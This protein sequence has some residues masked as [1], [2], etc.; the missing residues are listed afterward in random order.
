MLSISIPQGYG[1]NP[2]DQIFEDVLTHL[3][4]IYLHNNDIAYELELDLAQKMFGRIFAATTRDLKDAAIID[5]CTYLSMTLMNKTSVGFNGLVDAH[6]KVANKPQ[7]KV[8]LPKQSQAQAAAAQ[9]KHELSIEVDNIKQ[10]IEEKNFPVLIDISFDNVVSNLQVITVGPFYYQRADTLPI[11]SEFEKNYQKTQHGYLYLRIPINSKPDYE[12]L[13]NYLDPQ[14]VPD[15][16]VANA[17]DFSAVSKINDLSTAMQ[18][19]LNDL[20]PVSNMGIMARFGTAS[21]A[22]PRYNTFGTGPDNLHSFV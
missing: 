21:A 16:F 15:P 10:F 19:P 12:Q 4:E 8:A 2:S 1:E 9:I 7:E 20:Q 13:S 6:Q 3:R 14:E 11:E 17:N 18:A 22:P 5:L